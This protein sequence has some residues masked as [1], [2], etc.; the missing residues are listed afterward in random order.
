MQMNCAWESLMGLIPQWI[1]P[2][3]DRQKNVLQEMRLRIDKPPQLVCKGGEIWLDRTITRD[4]LNY[5]IN[6][7][8][9]YSP[10]AATTVS[11]G[12]I[13]A[14]GG[15]RLGICGEY[16]VKS[17]NTVAVH[18]VTSIC[19]RVARDFQ[20]IAE[21]I[22]KKRGS[23]LILGLPGS[24]K[25][26]FLRDVIRQRSVKS[27]TS[28]AVVDEKEEIFP[29]INHIPVFNTGKR[30]DVLSGCTKTTGI[31]MVLTNMGAGTIAIDEITE[32]SDCEALLK[33]CWCGVDLIATAHAANLRDLYTRPVYKPL[34]ESSVFKDVVVLSSDKTW[35]MERTS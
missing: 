7:A 2:A 31:N 24:G 6:T 10:W 35:T 13:T 12:Y 4:D 27:A 25:T 8:S 19:I 20:G 26:T 29:L 30:T 21:S 3:A 11:K 22:P 18:A 9:R 1:K 16:A 28:I 23:L 32:D 17:A 34:V 33:A 5:C 15:H 14:P